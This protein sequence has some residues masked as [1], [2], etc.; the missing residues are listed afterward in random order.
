MIGVDIDDLERLATDEYFRFVYRAM[1]ADVRFLCDGSARL[2][3]LYN[4]V[5]GRTYRAITIVAN[6]HLSRAQGWMSN[7][8]SAGYRAC[9][10]A[11]DHRH[12]R[13]TSVGCRTA[14]RRRNSIFLVTLSSLLASRGRL[15]GRR[16]HSCAF[17]LCSFD[18]PFLGRRS[19]QP[20][21]RVIRRPR[22]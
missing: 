14:R 8:R 20:T 19:I 18:S 6:F 12:S 4:G 13:A 15:P 3:A 10:I 21:T 16:L 7:T 11:I 17:C 5:C 1:S 9:F 2:L 22:V